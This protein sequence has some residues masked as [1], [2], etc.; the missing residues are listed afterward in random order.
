MQPCVLAAAVSL[1]FGAFSAPALAQSNTGALASQTLAQVVITGARFDSDPAMLPIGATVINAE[2]IRRAGVSDVNAVL[3]KVGGVYGR[4]SLDGSPDFSL[5]L[6]GFG[7]NSSQN[8]VVLL[9]GVRMSENELINPVLSS[10]AIDTIERIEITRGGSSVLYGEGATGGI[11]NIV[12][13]RAVAKEHHASVFTEVGK[14]GLREARAAGSMAW[15]GFAMDGSVGTQQTD[16]YRDNNEFKLF[17]ATLGAQ[18][19]DKDGRVGFRAD[20]S[21]Q[22]SRFPGA[23]NEAEFN[24]NPRRSKTPN[25]FGSLDT[26][27]V[28]GFVT[29]RF[30][31]LELAAELSHRERTSRATYVSSF[32]TYAT[33]FTGEQT[34]FSPRVRQLKE[35]GGMLNELVG[36]VD[37]A[38]WHRLATDPY[39]QTNAT[40]RSKALYLRDE[41][42]FDQAHDGRVALGVRRELFDKT[43]SSPATGPAYAVN[44]ALNAWELQGSYAPLPLLNVY[45][46]TGQS[47]RV[48]N[49]DENGYPKDFGVPLQPQVSHDLEL[50]AAYGN[51][52][53]KLTG[54]LFRHN[55]HNEIFYDPT[56]PFGGA[57]TN[58]D[59]TRRQGLELEAVARIAA[60]WN[61]HASYQHVKASFTEGANSGKDMVLVPK[62]VLSARL[63]WSPAGG[64]SADVGMQWVDSQRFGGDFSNTCGATM[65]S[66]AVFDARYARKFGQ[67]EVALTGLNLGDK[68][69]Y[70][71]AFSCKGGIYPSDGRQ[72]KVSA[73][74]D[75]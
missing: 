48:A 74:Y 57:N 36:G 45:A 55:L 2:Q 17:N 30:S 69:Y 18:W 59:P 6:R 22:D 8:M 68:H 49:A 40:Q 38:H 1:C 35:F 63:S 46:K 56:L 10:V 31:G 13:K 66:F 3:R 58:L 37:L 21:S 9:D 32:G 14:F 51:A 53:A 65:P 33:K 72:F 28:T 12:T 29:R 34:Q 15:D 43:A 42:R 71:E 26:N 67:W 73:R 11:I 41:L 64:H 47:Y 27:R 75:F 25:D 60:D 20:H 52:Q 16:N 39:S 54:R 19:F 61:V 50:G 70:S 4:Q 62:N 5:D 23:L 44:Q 24:A 7:N